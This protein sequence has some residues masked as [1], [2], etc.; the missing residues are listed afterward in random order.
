MIAFLAMSSLAVPAVARRT[1]KTRVSSLAEAAVGG[2]CNG[3]PDNLPDNFPVD[4]TR[5][6]VDRVLDCYDYGVAG[7]IDDKAAWALGALGREREPCGPE[8]CILLKHMLLNLKKNHYPFLRGAVEQLNNEDD[9]LWGFLRGNDTFSSSSIR[10]DVQKEAA[11]VLAKRISVDQLVNAYRTCDFICQRH[12]A[13]A[14]PKRFED[15]DK[16]TLLDV[17]MKV[18]G[19][20]YPDRA[21]TVAASEALFSHGHSDVLVSAVRKSRQELLSDR[22]CIARAALEAAVDKIRYESSDGITQMEV[23]DR[24]VGIAF[25]VGDIVR[26]KKFGYSVPQDTQGSITGLHRIYVD[27]AFVIDGKVSRFGNL[28]QDFLKVVKSKRGSV[29]EMAVGLQSILNEFTNTSDGEGWTSDDKVFTRE[30]VGKLASEDDDEDLGQK[31]QDFR[32]GFGQFR[33]SGCERN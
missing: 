14:L 25:A 31:F 3:V 32:R 12:L 7:S 23:R 15:A 26:F 20:G 8:R 13:E 21:I 27:V 10:F 6:Y 17:I 18:H 9:I 29:K 30:V 4:V 16:K 1:R 33:V 19:K 28:D 2:D 22:A 24:Q 5:D 11:G